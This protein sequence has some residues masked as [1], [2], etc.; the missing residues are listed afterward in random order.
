MTSLAAN[1]REHKK[2]ACFG[3]NVVDKPAM[4]SKIVGAGRTIVNKDS[5]DVDLCEGNM[6]VLEKMR[7]FSD[8]EVPIYD[9]RRINRCKR[10]R[11]REDRK[12]K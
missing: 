9:K 1:T 4:L 6:E 11:K 10:K 5:K 8:V 7:R 12:N 3:E 2:T